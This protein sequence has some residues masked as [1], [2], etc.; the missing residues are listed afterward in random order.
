MA[1]NNTTIYGI[2]PHTIYSAEPAKLKLWAAKID[3]T[4]P[5]NQAYG[6]FIRMTADSGELAGQTWM[7]DTYHLSPL[8]WSF[9]ATTESAIEALINCNTVSSHAIWAARSSCYYNDCVKLTE[10]NAKLFEEVCDLTKVEPL[11]GRNPD[12][13]ED[14]NV[15]NHIHL[16][17]EYGWSTYTGDSGITLLAKNAQVSTWNKAR[18]LAHEAIR[19]CKRYPTNCTHRV[20]DFE[21]YVFDKLDDADFRMLRDDVLTHYATAKKIA[22]VYRESNTHIDENQLVIPGLET[23]TIA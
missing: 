6:Q 16:Y 2:K 12:H 8:N 18:T 13:Y 5:Y 19:E 4:N 1:T 14:K 22:K 11:Y 15:F 3:E 20:K 10:E 7:I 17:R 9:G 23:E 21:T